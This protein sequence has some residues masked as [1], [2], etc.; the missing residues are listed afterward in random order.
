ME[1]IVSF[2]LRPIRFVW[3]VW[4]NITGRGTT[5]I[6]YMKSGNKIEV[7]FKHLTVNYSGGDINQIKWE[8]CLLPDN[9]WLHGDVAQIE[10]VV[11][12]NSPRLFG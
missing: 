5:Y 2:I 8:K 4:Q 12:K 11:I 10:A 6:F 7:Q 3:I 9:G 1:Y